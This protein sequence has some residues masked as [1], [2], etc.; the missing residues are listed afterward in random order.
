MFISFEKKKKHTPRNEGNQHHGGILNVDIYREGIVKSMTKLENVTKMPSS[1]YYNY[2][3]DFTLMCFFVG[4]D[5]LP[6]I[7]CMLNIEDAIDILI[8]IYIEVIY[9][10]EIEE[11][12]NI[13][14]PKQGHLTREDGTIIWKNLLLILE[15]LKGE[16]KLLLGELAKNIKTDATIKGNFTKNKKYI[17]NPLSLKKAIVRN[18]CLFHVCIRFSNIMVYTRIIIL[19][20]K[21]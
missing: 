21:E 16:E 20:R 13:F 17:F 19:K 7:M 1:I 5:F 11:G 14:K 8:E 3:R 4:N 2:V 18:T 6:C 15:S 12:R 9:N 10:P